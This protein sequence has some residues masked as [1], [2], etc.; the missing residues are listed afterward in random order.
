MNGFQTVLAGVE[1]RPHV[2]RPEKAAV[3]LVGPPV[4]GAD[5]LRRLARGLRT[6]AL[7]AMAADVVEGADRAVGAAHH[8][9]R[10]LAE[11]K[12]D[13]GPGLGQFRD[14]GREDPFPL[15]DMGEVGLVNR[16]IGMERPRE[17]PA[18]ALGADER[19]QRSLVH[20]G[21]F[22]GLCGAAAWLGS[23]T[24]AAEEPGV[25][26]AAV[27]RQIKL[28]ETD[29]SVPL[30]L[31]QHR[32]LVLTPSGQALAATVTA[33]L[34][35]LADM[36]ETL[37]QPDL[38][39]TVTVGATLAFNH[40]WILPRLAGF[41]AAH[42]EIKLKLVADDGP[43]DLRRDRLDVVIRYGKEPFADA[44]SIASRGDRA[45]PVCSPELLARLGLETEAADLSRLPLV[46]SDSLNPSRLT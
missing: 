23:F 24:R 46:A 17:R 38:P 15:P 33:A 1:V 27:S 30:F 12:R 14:G 45:F 10:I 20:H 41:R 40:F 25:T 2:A 16:G 9:D 32:K 22:L 42:P 39:S 36:V 11:L 18:P 29:L 19:K 5:E 26:Q 4:V 28:V 37:R 3:R 44:P 8:H 7:A 13:I 6:E 43:T 34:R 31:R 35:G 21:S